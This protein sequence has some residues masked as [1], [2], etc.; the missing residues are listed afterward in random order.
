MNIELFLPKTNIGVDVKSSDI[1][2]K[3]N[4]PNLQLYVGM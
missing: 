4:N 2:K 3:T 1:L